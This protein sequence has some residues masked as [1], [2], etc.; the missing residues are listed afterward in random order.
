LA[1]D[2]YIHESGTI[3]AFAVENIFAGPAR[4]MLPRRIIEQSIRL[5]TP[6]PR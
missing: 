3:F 6:A 1:I 2:K 5:S 4:F